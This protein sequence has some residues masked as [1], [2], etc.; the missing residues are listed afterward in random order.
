MATFG[1]GPKLASEIAIPAAPDAGEQIATAIRKRSGRLLI[2]KDA[3][4]L[5]RIQR[6][7]PTTYWRRIVRG[8]PS[9][10]STI[11]PKDA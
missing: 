11:A 9:V 1:G 2:G 4:M 7:F 5:D 10:A 8:Q 3:R 6:I